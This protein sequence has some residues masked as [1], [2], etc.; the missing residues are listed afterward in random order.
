M[1]RERT[2]FSTTDEFQRIRAASSQQRK[3]QER[4]AERGLFTQ[5]DGNL[6]TKTSLNFEFTGLALYTKGLA[7][8]LLIPTF[9]I[10]N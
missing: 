9:R 3:V 7:L 1:L 2:S 6:T 8:L 10:Q 4:E 5:F